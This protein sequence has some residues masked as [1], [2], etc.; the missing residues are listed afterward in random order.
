LSSHT[1]DLVKMSSVGKTNTNE[2]HAF[3]ARKK[4][5]LLLEPVDRRRGKAAVCR[6][7]RE[8]LKERTGKNVD[9]LRKDGPKGEG[10]NN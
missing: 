10:H 2:K 5:L 4:I 9:K 3:T 6:G 7:M 8:R 1:L